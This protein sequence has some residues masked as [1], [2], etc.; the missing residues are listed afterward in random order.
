M[1]GGGVWIVLDYQD[2][3]EIRQDMLEHEDEKMS[4]YLRASADDFYSLFSKEGGWLNLGCV[5]MGIGAFTFF[6]SFFGFCGVH[7][8]SACLL[9]TYIFLVTIGMI[10]QVCSAAILYNR[11]YEMKVMSN[12]L[13]TSSDTKLSSGKCYEKMI[14]FLFS[15]SFSTVVM[16]LLIVLSILVRQT[17]SE[18]F[19]YLQPV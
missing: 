9:F 3:M 7:E 16:V 10:L 11:G 8:K 6:V 12:M 19:K 2:S 18:G 15:G 1:M 13:N 5:S 17:E 14:F 4:E